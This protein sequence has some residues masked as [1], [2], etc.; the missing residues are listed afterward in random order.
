MS[1]L[2][3]L[4]VALAAAGCAGDR[5][6]REAANARQATTEPTAEATVPVW[7]DGRYADGTLEFRYPGW[8]KRTNSETWAQLLSDNRS[9]HPAFI[10]VRYLDRPLPVTGSEFGRLAGRTLRPPHGRGLTLLYTQTTRL[11][12]VRGLEA[13]FV[14]QTRATTPLGP[15]MR[16]FGVELP[17]GG[18]ALVV[19]AAERPQLHAGA[20]G[21]VRKTVRWTHSPRRAAGAVLPSRGTRSY[22]RLVSG[23][24]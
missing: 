3:P 19:F 22:G 11:G 5:E 8:W 4:L 15:T 24:S 21:W 14:W 17:G 16:A 9:R 10:S 6:P 1:R 23:A 7:L 13:T 20:F 12:D 2:A 18:S